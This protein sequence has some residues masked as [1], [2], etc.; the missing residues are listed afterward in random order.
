MNERDVRL[1]KKL[2]VPEGMEKPVEKN[3]SS[4][5]EGWRL[6]PRNHNFMIDKVGRRRFLPPQVGC[7]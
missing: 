5:L 1:L 6:D 2:N 3:K 7:G 4:S